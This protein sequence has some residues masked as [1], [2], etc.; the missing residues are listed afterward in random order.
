MRIEHTDTL[1]QEM[2]S[3]T[4]GYVPADLTTLCKEASIHAISRILD[5]YAIPSHSET[6]QGEEQKVPEFS[7]ENLTP[8]QVEQMYVT[9]DDFSF[10]LKKVQPSA[11]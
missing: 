11:Q 9:H 7:F 2:A 3:L 10:A 8:E 6:T 4:P 5:T 1:I